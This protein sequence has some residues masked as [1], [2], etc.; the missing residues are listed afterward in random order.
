MAEIAYEV[1]GDERVR[2]DDHLAS[3][4]E[5]A[6]ELAEEEGPEGVGVLVTGSVATAGQARAYLRSARGAR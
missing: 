5:L 6:I 1:F 3:A 4:V 2:V